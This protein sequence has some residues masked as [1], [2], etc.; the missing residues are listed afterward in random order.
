MAEGSAAVKN[1]A[2]SRLGTD[3]TEAALYIDGWLY[4]TPSGESGTSTLDP[5]GTPPG[6]IAPPFLCTGEDRSACHPS[7]TVSPDIS[8]DL[9][10][11]TPRV[12][13]VMICRF[14]N[15]SVYEAALHP[16]R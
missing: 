9:D 14:C 5:S 15:L 13:K 7:D 6:C 1:N 3:A 10:T 4:A 8:R 2:D 12:Q 16:N 11:R